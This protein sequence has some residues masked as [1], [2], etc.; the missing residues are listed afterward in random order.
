M[1]PY[2]ASYTVKLMFRNGI[3]QTHQ[4]PKKYSNNLY[5][6]LDRN[7]NHPMS[8]IYKTSVP[9]LSSMTLVK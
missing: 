8:I 5:L 9:L 6:N 3:M 2:I 1:G 4:P 7:K